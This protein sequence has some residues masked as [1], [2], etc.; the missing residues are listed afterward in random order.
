MPS[1]RSYPRT[2]AP[3]AGLCYV[4]RPILPPMPW[5]MYAQVTGDDL[6][7]VFACL[8]SLQHVRNPVPAPQHPATG[9]IQA[10]D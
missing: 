5:P 6:R 4:G 8:Q 3:V 1:P 7:F 10:K 2:G 9:Q